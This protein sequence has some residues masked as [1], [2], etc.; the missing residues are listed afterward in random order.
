MHC[1]GQEFESP[2]VHPRRRIN[3][4]TVPLSVALFGFTPYLPIYMTD[5]NPP[6]PIMHLSNA[7]DDVQPHFALV[8]SKELLLTFWEISGDALAF[9]DAHGIVLAVNPAYYELYGY[10]PDEIIGKCFADIFPEEAREWAVE[11]YKQLF[12]SPEG[13]APVEATVQRKDGSPR[14]VDV[15]YTFVER[16][17]QRIGMLSSIRDITERKET[18]QALL[19]SQQELRDFVENASVGLHWVGPDGV[20][21]WANQA[22]LDLLGYSREEYIG[23]H[24]A[25]FHI[26]REVIDNIL[27]KLAAGET[28]QNYE[29][30]MRC[31]DGSIR[32]V[33]INSN[34]LWEDGK[35]IHTRCFTRDVT[36][37]KRAE[38]ELARMLVLE[39]KAHALADSAVRTRHEMLSVVSHDLKNPLAVIKGN[40]QLLSRRLSRIATSESDKHG[41]LSLIERADQ[42][43]SKMNMLLD[44]LLD[45]GAVQEGQLLSLQRQPTDLV[46]LCERI[47]KEHQVSA[48]S[49]RIHL[50]SDVE[51][52][53][54]RWDSNR[55]ERVVVNLISNAIKYSSAGSEVVINLTREENEENI[56]GSLAVLAIRDQG[57]G[58]PKDEL[59][60]IFEWFR[61]ARN[62]STSVS[63]AGIGLANARQVVEQHGGTIDVES[64]EGVGSTFVVRLP[65]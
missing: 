23:H 59:P 65:V 29:A 57:V 8:E 21:L 19:H 43:V 12:S 30:Q 55:L 5:P 13:P 49:H 60:H 50:Q 9:S 28:L 31:K 63:G 45:F 46:A 14:V 48:K 6:S 18:E 27:T 58:I 42:A 17:G 47:V 22:E 44:E 32:H 41:L 3:S 2:Q 24:I 26:D 37:R 56:E 16:N 53:V 35:F 4:A 34:V 7:T 51:R 38:E 61:R 1:G 25:E 64:Q 52:L 54:G 62:V 11:G 33:S 15:R 10:G 40:N 20:I 36:E 39:Q